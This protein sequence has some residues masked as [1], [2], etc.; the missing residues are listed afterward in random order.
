MSSISSLRGQPVVT[1]G[2]VLLRLSSRA[3]IPLRRLRGLDTFPAGA[4]SNVACNLA[5]LGHNVT[6]VSRLPDTPLARGLVDELRRFGV[7]VD[8]IEWDQQG[9]LGTFFVQFAV[10]PQIVEVH[11][12]RSGSCATL[13]HPDEL[14]AALFQSRCL[15]HVSGITSALSASAHA[16][17]LR[18]VE[19]AR[20]GGGRVSFDVNY[21]A[22]LWSPDAAARRLT[23]MLRSCE[24]L[25]C[26]Q[27]D[28]QALWKMDGTGEKL[29][30]QLRD[31]TCAS[32]IVSSDGAQGV[33]AALDHEVVFQ[34]SV[35]VNPIDRLGAGDALAAGFLHRLL[36][37]N[38]S[39][40]LPTAVTLAAIALTTEGDCPHCSREDL[41][42]LIDA[43][44]DTNP[45]R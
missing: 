44:S 25:F 18:A 33:W 23:P 41:D 36:Q 6:F 28:A 40:A 11:Y 1:L 19:L 35:P 38:M 30:Q 8:H 17:V 22:K 3:G 5:Q 34:S 12:D 39:R 7:G 20:A 10:P 16:T 24:V 15:F 45:L 37:D 13:L 27:R 14:D 32:Y 31:V 29:I 2:E 43:E 21:R 9:R 26:S 42:R 4:E